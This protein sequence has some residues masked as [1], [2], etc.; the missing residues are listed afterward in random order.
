MNVGGSCWNG[1]M[2]TPD[3]TSAALA[4]QAD[5]DRIVALERAHPG[6]AGRAVAAG[7]AGARVRARGRG[8]A[9]RFLAGA[10]RVR[11]PIVPRRARDRPGGARGHRRRAGRRRGDAARRR[12]TIARATI[13][14]DARGAVLGFDQ[15]SAAALHLRGD[16]RASRRCRR[17][18]R[19]SGTRA[20]HRSRPT[21]HCAD[22]CG[23]CA[24]GCT[25]SHSR[26]GIAPP[27]SIGGWSSSRPP[28]AWRGSASSSKPSVPSPSRTASIGS[29]TRRPRP[30]RSS[31][32]AH[33]RNGCSMPQ[34]TSS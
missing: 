18:T 11:H 21:P 34:P 2:T 15:P 1:S 10:A 29:S 3:A 33:V 23:R 7:R 22:G 26:A 13:A 4:L 5:L 19:V 12:R 30:R 9:R 17:R 32:T 28:T 14:P 16:H 6:G 25:P 24:N 31:T 20:R 8:G 27:H